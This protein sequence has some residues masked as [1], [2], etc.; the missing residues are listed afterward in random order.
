MKMLLAS[1]GSKKKKATLRFAAEVAQALAAET[2]LLGVVDEEEQVEE[3]ER[4]LYKVAKRLAG[5]GLPASFQVEAGQAEEILMAE[6]DRIDGLT[7]VE[8]SQLD[9]D[10]TATLCRLIFAD[11]RHLL[12]KGSSDLIEGVGQLKAFTDTYH[13]FAYFDRVSYTNIDHL[14][15]NYRNF[16]AL[17]SFRGYGKQDLL[18]IT[19]AEARVPSGITRVLLPKRALRFNLRL[20]TLRSRLTLEEKQVP[21]PG[22]PS[23]L[24]AVQVVLSLML[25]QVAAGACTLNDLAD[26]MSWAPARVWDIVDKGRIVEGYDADL[27]LDAESVEG[28]RHRDHPDDGEQQECEDDVEECEATS[29]GREF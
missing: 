7:V 28:P 16:T 20:D 12:L 24:P 25:N 21:Y 6:I 10:D 29:H 22:S 13:R 15:R 17:V 23:G 19:E 4:A 26:W 8:G 1:V 14:R 5:A 2:T 11:G 18:T 9:H 27:V 3:L